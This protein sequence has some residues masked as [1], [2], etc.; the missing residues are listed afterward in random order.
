MNAY[1]KPYNLLNDSKFT[2]SNDKKYQNC[3]DSLLSIYKKDMTDFAN[4][5]L[6]RISMKG[7]QPEEAIRHFVDWLNSYARFNH[8]IQKCFMYLNRNALR[9][10]GTCLYF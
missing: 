2:V 8:W 4:V 7:L 5:M 9:A 10:E 6:T 3:G 1:Q